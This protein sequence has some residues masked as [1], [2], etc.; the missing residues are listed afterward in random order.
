VRSTRA[1]HLLLGAGFRNLHNLKGG[2]NGWAK[3]VDPNQP[4]Y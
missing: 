2:L 3:E 4:V 1:L